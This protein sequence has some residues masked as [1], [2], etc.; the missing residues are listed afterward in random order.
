MPRSLNLVYMCTGGGI[1]GGL[2][3]DERLVLAE[4]LLELAAD[5]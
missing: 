3:E 1:R 5:G 2:K 4:I